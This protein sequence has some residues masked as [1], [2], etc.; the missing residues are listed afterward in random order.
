MRKILAEK[1]QL[2]EETT[3]N[4]H[5]IEENNEQEE[6]VEERDEGRTKEMKSASDVG[7]DEERITDTETPEPSQITEEVNKEEELRRSLDELAKE[8]EELLQGYI[9][10][11][12]DFDN[13][14]RR[15]REEL[16]QAKDQGLEDLVIKLLPVLDNMERA[17]DSSGDLHRWREGVEMVLRQF[18]GVLET[19]GLAA[20]AGPGEEFDPNKHE[21]IARETSDQ[22]E[23]TIIEEL[24]KG[25]Q[26]KGKTIRASLVKVSAGRDG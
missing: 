22:P 20:I 12:A 2:K 17:I 25:Y 23:N 14:R 7:I 10:L 16:N 13:Y 18:L 4:Q 3:H 9:R 24:R 8:K 1:G 6:T 11:K 26:L 19:E 21:A 15:T 5:V